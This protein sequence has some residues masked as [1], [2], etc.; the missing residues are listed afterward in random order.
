MNVFYKACLLASS[1]THIPEQIIRFGVIGCL[2]TAFS[3]I[4]FACFIFVG[5]H[6]MLATLLA[7]IIGTFFS[8]KTLGALVFDNPDNRLVVKFFIVYGFCYFLSIGL[9]YLLARYVFP[10]RYING[11]ISMFF[12]AAISFCLNKWV[13]FR[14]KIPAEQ[15]S[16]F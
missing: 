5:L 15:V 11:F 13:V 2:N 1:V 6:Y 8:F 14:K 12:V 10:N 4:I 16:I 3:Y 7:T 9:Q